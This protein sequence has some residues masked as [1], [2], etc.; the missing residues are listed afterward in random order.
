MRLPHL[1][2]SMTRSKALARLIE[3]DRTAVM[4]EHMGAVLQ[5]DQEMG[6]SSLALEERSTQL[7]W[8]SSQVHE[9]T[10]GSEMAELLSA[11]DCDAENPEGSG[12]DAFEKALLRIRYRHWD[13]QRALPTSLVKALG[14]QGSRGHESWARARKLND[15]NL[16]KDDLQKIITLVREKES[17]YR[18]EGF[19]GYDVLLDDFEVGMRTEEV[20]TLFTTIREPLLALVDTLAAKPCHDSFLYE[21][22]P[23]ERQ[24][25]FSRRV[26]HDMGFD[27]QRGKLALSVHPFTSTLGSDDIRI[28]T[29]Y[30]D[31]SVLDALSST[32]HEGG[33]ALYEMGMNSGRLKGSSVASAA[34]YGMHESQSRLWENMVAKSEPFW[35]HYYPDFQALFPS[36]T[37][38]IKLD[39]FLKAVN[40]VG[41]TLIRVNADEVSYSLHVMLRFELEEELLFG[42]LSVEDLPDAWRQRS[43]RLLGVSPS[44][45]AEGVLQDVHWS[46]GDFGY[47]PTYALGNLY[48]AQIWEAM[49]KSIPVDQLMREGKLE[50]L[51]YYLKSNIHEKGSLL[52]PAQLLQEVSGKPLDAKLFTSYLEH[53]FS[54]LFGN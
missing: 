10:T 4:L 50:E 17:C 49:G 3:I 11:L 45:D 2:R 8:L 28:T 46:G 54:R 18:K 19:S 26:L 43:Q 15:W 37:R 27:F 6:I 42:N 39:D 35:E 25:E 53:K 22:Y 23:V 14:E 52:F 40:R 7:G 29:R 5:W 44:S 1:E 41:R 47:F 36:Q 9:M 31:P 30:T 13:K 48:G 33:H 24:E 34:S 21:D 12:E 38:A 20:R 32:I 16:F 51:Q